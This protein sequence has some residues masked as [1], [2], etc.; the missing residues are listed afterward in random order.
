MIHLQLSRR[1]D[2]SAAAEGGTEGFKG[3][4][5]GDKPLNRHN[6]MGAHP[7]R[8][9]IA[10]EVLIAVRRCR[11]LA[12]EY[13]IEIGPKVAVV[14]LKGQ[15]DGGDGAQPCADT[16]AAGAAFTEQVPTQ[17]GVGRILGEVR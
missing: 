9:R 2:Y 1:A 16:A 17:P 10:I 8:M 3:A 12:A 14:N 7:L 11:N 15:L 13:R 6:P 4:Y 5:P